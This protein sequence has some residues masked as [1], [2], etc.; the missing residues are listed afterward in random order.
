MGIT[1]SNSRGTAT[2][3]LTCGARIQRGSFYSEMRQGAKEGDVQW[4]F[5]AAAAP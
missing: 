4:N 1:H 5:L 3:W 2:T